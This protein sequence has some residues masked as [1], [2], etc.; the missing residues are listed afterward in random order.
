MS[1]GFNVDLEREAP[2]PI[3]RTS[4]EV[5]AAV[6]DIPALV[7]EHRPRAVAFAATHGSGSEGGAAGKLVDWLLAA[8]R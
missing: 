5:A 3:V 6:R 1:P 8:G 2:G 7:A 4:A